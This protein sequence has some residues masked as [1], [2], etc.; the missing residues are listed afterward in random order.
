M[1]PPTQSKEDYEGEKT[2]NLVAFASKLCVHVDT[3]C[4]IGWGAYG[5]LCTIKLE[6]KDDKEKQGDHNVESR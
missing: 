5:M 4:N 6:R 1:D 2:I 3:E